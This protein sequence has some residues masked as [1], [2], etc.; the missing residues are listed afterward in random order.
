VIPGDPISGREE[1]LKAVLRRL[2]SV[3]V[4]FSGGVDSTFLL[5]M[6]LDSLGASAV[7]AVTAASPSLPAAELAKAGALA[8]ELGGRHLVVRT[9]ELSRPGYRANGGD[10]CAFCKSELL[11]VLIPVARRENLAQVATGTNADD[12]AAGFRP[13]I[14]AAAARGAVTPLVATGWVKADIREASRRRGLRTWDQPAAACLASRV[15]YGTEVSARRL[16]R[17]ERAEAAARDA[18]RAAGVPVRNLRVR[19]L[20]PVAGGTGDLARIEVDA[21]LVSTVRDC[22]AV[23]S[24]VTSAG[25]GRAEL[26]PRG[27]RSGSMNDLLPN[28]ERY[29]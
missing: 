9:D 5:A 19:D 24:A 3:L 26:D 4:A 29:R 17:I 21:H 6:A 14:R 10:R 18:L 2:G 12:V 25:F 1:R 16:A 20:G 23:L 28:P 11:D 27:F 15:R 13:G 22:P 8:A 7:L